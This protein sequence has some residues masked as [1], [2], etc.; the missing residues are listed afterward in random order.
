[1]KFKFVIGLCLVILA[2]ALYAEEAPAIPPI[3]PEVLA[4]FGLNLDLGYDS[5]TDP[6]TGQSIGW[7]RIGFK[8][9]LK[10]GEFGVGLDIDFRY[11]FN[12][13]ADGNTFELREGDWVPDPERNFFEVYLPKIR[14]LS[15]GSKGSPV[16]LLFGNVEN[17]LLGNGFI[18]SSYKNTLYQPEHRV[19]GASFDLDFAAVQFPYI[20]FETMVANIAAFDLLAARIYFRP[21]AGTDIPLLKTLQ[22]GV[23]VAADSNPYYYNDLTKLTPPSEAVVMWGADLKIP[24]I[25]EKD[26]GLSFFGDIAGQKESTGGQFGLGGSIASIVKYLALVRLTQDNFLPSYFDSSYDISREQK[27]AVYTGAATTPGGAGWLVSLGLDIP[28]GVLF[29][30][31]VDGPF[32]PNSAIPFMNPNLK[33]ILTISDELLGGFGINAYYTKKDITSFEALI[34]PTNAVVGASISYK[35]GPAIIR[36]V[37]DLKYDPYSVTDQNWTVNSKIETSI[38]LF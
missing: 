21:L 3:D 18:V 12:G 20:G 22:L 15:Y 31:I 23:T 6:L 10:V 1:M 25:A 32:E 4:D 14:Y 2:G 34:D 29:S 35:A 33:I 28:E 37:Y 17:G 9:D 36:L 19:F 11:R 38:E 24:I 16:Y 30:A 27:Y 5:F 7:Q 13:G 26:F 8:P